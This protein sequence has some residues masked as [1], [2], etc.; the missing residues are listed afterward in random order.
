MRLSDSELGLRLETAAGEFRRTADDL[1][2]LADTLPRRAS[3][4]KSW[5]EQIATR[6][7]S[8][9]DGL[10]AEVAN[11]DRESVGLLRRLGTRRVAMVSL[12]VTG[13]VAQAATSGVLGAAGLDL[14]EQIS[15]Q[16]VVLERAGNE[17]DHADT[18]L[19]DR[20]ADALYELD[21]SHREVL[22]LR[23]GLGT[24]EALTEHAI[25]QRLNITEDAVRLR[26]RSALQRFEELTQL[27][28]AAAVDALKSAPSTGSR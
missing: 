2:R 12:A 7:V 14:Y 9:A 10:S 4:Q 28:R 15:S 17:L 25:G 8:H 20:V 18:R 19:S 5:L 13:W 16:V 26:M 11:P 22:V 1:T 27:D 24:E 6:L 23:F 21:R 3:T